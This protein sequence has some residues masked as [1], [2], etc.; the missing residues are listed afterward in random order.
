[1]SSELLYSLRYKQQ[2]SIQIKKTSIWSLSLIF[3]CDMWW[4]HHYRNIKN[5]VM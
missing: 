2:L 3:H 4:T 1:M 5:L